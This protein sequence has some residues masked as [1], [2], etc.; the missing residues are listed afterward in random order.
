MET[1]L[2]AQQP[3]PGPID[4]EAL[5]GS[6]APTRRGRRRHFFDRVSLDP[7]TQAVKHRCARLA[8]GGWVMATV[9]A[10]GS[11]DG[12]PFDV[13]VG[14][15]A[16]N[17]SDGAGGGSAGIANGG[18]SAGSAT[19]GSAAG[20]A[21]AGVSGGNAGG[22]AAG[23]SATGGGATGGNAAG[24]APAGG[25]AG[26]SGTANQAGAASGA[27]ESGGFGGTTAG[28]GGTAGIAGGSG[29]GGLGMAGG[30]GESGACPLDLVG[31][32]TLEGGTTG[33][34][35]ATPTTVTSQSAL[36]ACATANEPRVCRVQG[37]ITFS[38]F[39]EIRVTSNKTII[40]AGATAEIVMGGFFVGGGNSN[41]IIRN[42][43]IRDSQI[44][45]D[46]EGGDRDG[47]QL[48]TTHH[49]WIDHCRFS[50]LGDGQIDSR[51]DTTLETVSWNILEE[52]NKAFG[53]GWTPNVTAEMTIHHN[54]IRDTVQRNPSTDNVL[55]AH[56]FNN[57]LEDVTS[58]GNYSRG[59]TNMVLQNSVFVNVNDPHYYDTGTLVATG[60]I[61]RNTTGQQEQSGT[62][63]SFFDPGDFYA[64]TLDP[65][66]E[67]EAL[68][69][70]CAGPRPELGN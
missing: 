21:S 13:S 30:G 60:N 49:I 58:Y 14:G 33:G 69:K 57:L 42:L 35:N 38:P 11:D 16:G 26:A 9:M 2:S 43:T 44:D 68:V 62:E 23:G 36:K 27:G 45:G 6:R 50:R 41:V 8:L 66:S 7:N 19:G 56:L 39:E 40:G 46:S 61:Y 48:D 47:I 12:Q 24:G 70:R 59:G 17:H 18:A 53:I 34:G 55:R 51:K 29:A 28:N 32:A 25:N 3:E 1:L 64:Y 52:H 4:D 10:C 5:K 22:G 15:R 54:W 65:A 31:F 20:G 63:F 37:T 67:V